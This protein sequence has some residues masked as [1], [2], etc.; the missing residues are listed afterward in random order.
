ML[1]ARIPIVHVVLLVKALITS[2]TIG[3]LV[4]GSYCHAGID[5]SKDDLR[6]QQFCLFH[7][8]SEDDNVSGGRAEESITYAGPGAFLHSQTGHYIT[9]HCLTVFHNQPGHVLLG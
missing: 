1:Y 7:M 3:I 4:V 8:V 6:A 9:Y 2:H 5:P